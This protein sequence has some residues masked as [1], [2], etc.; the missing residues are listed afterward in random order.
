MSN[1]I[2]GASF[3][4]VRIAR[5]RYPVSVTHYTLPM[6]GLKPELE[7]CIV[8]HVTDIH[9]GYG[10]TDPVYSWLTNALAD[11]NPSVVLFTGDYVDDH[12]KGPGYPLGDVLKRLKGDRYAAAVY[13]NHDHRR[14]LVEAKDGL[15]TANIP[16][17]VNDSLQL[18]PGLWVGGLDDMYE[19][20]PDLQRTLA[21]MP[22][23]RSTILL[24]H[25]PTAIEQTGDRNVVIL[26]GHTH[27]AQMRLPWPS[28]ELVCRVHLRCRQV[29]GW[30]HNG[31]ARL[32]ISRGIG[33]TGWPPLRI[34]CPAELAVFHLTAAGSD[35]RASSAGKPAL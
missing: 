32:Y 16:L 34:A 28:P 19:G 10:D 13:G 4:K 23:D 12:Y 3:A 21:R 15:E 31:L 29:M 22:T 30:Y 2:P 11:I 26:S 9:C 1:A 5:R 14:G 27:G 7:G 25:N 6:V 20:S 24:S 17:L 8:A 18:L 35:F 33:V